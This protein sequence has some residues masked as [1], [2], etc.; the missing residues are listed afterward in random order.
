MAGAVIS[1]GLMLLA[2][3]LVARMLGKTGYGQLGMIQS[4]VGMFGVLAGFGLGLTATKHVAEFRKSDPLRAGRII[5]LSGLVALTTGSLM[6]LGLF[7]FAPWLAE[8]TLNAP[9]LSGPLRISAAMLFISALNGAQTGALSGF[10]AFKTIAHVN[11]LAGLLAFPMLVIGAYFGGLAGAV[12]AMTINLGINWLLNHLALRK[13]AARHGV[14]LTFR[15]C[16]RELSILWRFTLPAVLGGVLVGPANWACSALLVNQPRG[17]GELGVYNAI[18]CVKQVPEMVLAMLMAPLLPMLS[19]SFGKGDSH[20]YNKMLRYAF[21]LSLCVVVPISLVQAAM[22]TLTLLPYGQDYQGHTSVVQWLMFHAVLVG[23]FQPFGSM[24]ASMN[25]MWFGFAYNLSW[26]AAFMLL[27]YLFVPR[28]G[29]SGLAVALA[30]ATCATSIPCVLYVYLRERAFVAQIPGGRLVASVLLSFTICF[31]AERYLAPLPAMG[32][33]V[34][35]AIGL[36]V[37]S[38]TLARVE[39][40]A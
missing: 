7:I 14:P 5:G 37:F 10:E 40:P 29:G 3:I 26:A 27:A 11:L 13:E 16:T 24:L 2:L 30:M 1:R 38:V 28:Y 31:I 36:L 9:H 19:E 25:R 35:V 6:A 21:A 12:W 4:T 32:I 33:G 15:T 18:L 34:M 23:L 8:H 39:R 17:Y 22:P 20:S